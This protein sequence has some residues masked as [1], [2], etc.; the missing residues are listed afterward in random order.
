[1]EW[2]IRGEYLIKSQKTERSKVKQKRKKNQL[3][4]ILLQSFFQFF[5]PKGFAVSINSDVGNQMFWSGTMPMFNVFGAGNGV[6]FLDHYDCLTSF[7]IIAFAFNDNQDLTCGVLLPI[8]GR[9]RAKSGLCK[10][11]VKTRICFNQPGEP[12]TSQI[13]EIGS[14]FFRC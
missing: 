12:S 11:V 5:C 8:Q 10:V 3:L 6:S 1:M 13:M 2:E 9:I 14:L 7:L 4:L